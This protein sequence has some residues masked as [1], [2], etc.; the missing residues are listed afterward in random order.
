LLEETVFSIRACSNRSSNRN[1]GTVLAQPSNSG[2]VEANYSG[3]R[4]NPLESGINLRHRCLSGNQTSIGKHS[5]A[6]V[7]L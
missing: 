4:S 7:G 3:I 2:F 6:L 1:I 5:T